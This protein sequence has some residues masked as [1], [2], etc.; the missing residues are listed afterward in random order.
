MTVDICYYLGDGVLD[1]HVP[2]FPWF[3]EGDPESYKTYVNRL[4]LEANK[5]LSESSP[6][7]EKKLKNHLSKI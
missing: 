6:Y 2:Y 4:T 3:V 5:I 1:S 7:S